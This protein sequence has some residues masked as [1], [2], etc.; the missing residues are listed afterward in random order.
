MNDDFQHRPSKLSELLGGTKA[1]KLISA[2]KKCAGPALDQQA[3]FVGVRLVE[4]KRTLL[5]AIPDPVWRQELEFQ[6]N[7]ILKVY[8][9]ALEATGFPYSE[10]PTAIE[11]LANEHSTLKGKAVHSQK[12]RVK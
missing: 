8:C 7:E 10:I 11:L 6:K 4:S 2:W 12:S 1:L 3:Q 9:K 5:L